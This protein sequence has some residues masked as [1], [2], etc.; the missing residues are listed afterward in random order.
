[1]KLGVL[2]QSM[3]YPAYGRST[4][5]GDSTT[6]A[7]ARPHQELKNTSQWE[8]ALMNSE[9][10]LDAIDWDLQMTPKTSTQP[11][12]ACLDRNCLFLMDVS[13]APSPN[14]SPNF[15]PGQVSIDGF[16]RLHSLRRGYELSDLQPLIELIHGDNSIHF[17]YLSCFHW[18]SPH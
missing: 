5:T 3:L 7:G 18:Q 4:R 15:S 10:I 9:T 2:F 14:P 11:I 6:S 1:M 17:A 12:C 16:H 13:Q 8:S